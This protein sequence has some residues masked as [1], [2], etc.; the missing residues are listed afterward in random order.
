VQDAATT[1]ATAS[2]I[3]SRLGNVAPVAQQA[4]TAV[5]SLSTSPA[6]TRIANALSKFGS[7]SQL[8]TWQHLVDAMIAYSMGVVSGIQ[9]STL[10]AS[11]SVETRILI[12]PNQLLE[13]STMVLSVYP[14][15]RGSRFLQDMAQTIDN[16]HCKLPDFYMYKTLTCACGDEAVKITSRR[17]NEGVDLHAHWCTGTL[18]LLDGFGR[19]TYVRNPYTFAELL[20]RLDGKVEPYLKCISQLGDGTSD[21]KDCSSLRPRVPEIDDKNSLDILSIS[22][23]QRCRA[24]YQQVKYAVVVL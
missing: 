13:K 1:S 7:R 3:F 23:L 21:I 10:C 24:N 9:V 4:A 22:V 6:A 8:A 16:V 18:K 17:A 19:V 5:G 11:F 14:L 2:N 12:S 20:S 15:I